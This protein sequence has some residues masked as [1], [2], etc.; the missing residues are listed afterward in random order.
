MQDDV[1]SG[2]LTGLP[3]VSQGVETRT[4]ASKKMRQKGC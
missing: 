3:D 1:I 2:L 4:R